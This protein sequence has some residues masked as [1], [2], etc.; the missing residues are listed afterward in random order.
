MFDDKSGMVPA[1]ETQ[2]A[3]EMNRYST[4]IEDLFKV[5]E[6]LEMRLD[7]VLEKPNQKA[8]GGVAVQAVTVELAQKLSDRNSQLARLREKLEDLHQRIEL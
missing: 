3:R 4:L 6:A 1:R 5:V 2:V 7:P 8:S